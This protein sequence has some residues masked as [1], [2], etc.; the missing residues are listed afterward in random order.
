MTASLGIDY[1]AA[2][3]GEHGLRR[4]P[5]PSARF[6]ATPIAELDLAALPGLRQFSPDVGIVSDKYRLALRRLLAASQTR[7][8][9]ERRTTDG[10]GCRQIQA[11]TNRPSPK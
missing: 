4:H 1:G 5:P 6:G 2:G 10:Y 3:H 11:G 7:S 9:S 8:E